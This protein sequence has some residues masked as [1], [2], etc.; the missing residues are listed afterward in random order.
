MSITALS[1]V[2]SDSHIKRLE[3]IERPCN[4]PDAVCGWTTKQL[5][6]AAE[7]TPLLVITIE[8]AVLIGTMKIE[9][10]KRYR[11]NQTN[12]RKLAE[13]PHLFHCTFRSSLVVAKWR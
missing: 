4:F 6:Y 13:L 5:R 11:I 2:D 7:T 9:V 10:W 3:T 1:R 12:G 8:A